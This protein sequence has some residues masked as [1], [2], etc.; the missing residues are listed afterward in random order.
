MSAG[1]A[2]YPRRT[3]AA[4]FRAVPMRFM[5]VYIL[6]AL[7]VGVL[8]PYNDKTLVGI[9]EGTIA[10]GGT[11]AASPY[12]IAMNRLKV[13]S[14]VPN[15]VNALILSSVVSAGNSY[16]FYSSRTLYGLAIRHHAPRVL[17]LTNRHGVPYAAVLVSLGFGC[18]SFLQVSNSSSV[19]LTWFTNIITASQVLNYIFCLILYLVYR[20]AMKAQGKSRDSLHF[21]AWWQPYITY[22]ALFFLTI[23]VFIQGYTVFLP[24]NWS[25][26][27]FFTYYF[28]I[29][30]CPCFFIFWKVLKRT[31]FVS[32]HEANLV[33]EGP[34]IDA[35]ESTLPDEDISLIASLKRAYRHVLS[36]KS[37]TSDESKSPSF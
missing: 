24:G 1:E 36:R 9:F 3:M 15:L 18:L 33:L 7:A 22:F 32:P 26:E 25:V 6:G 37:K 21:R 34:L 16:I 29:L 8:V 4:A 28:M 14:F 23:L 20:R 27:D 19:V 11:G 30:A 12:V 17:G 13:S 31:K 5:F 35:Y 10:G 2:Y